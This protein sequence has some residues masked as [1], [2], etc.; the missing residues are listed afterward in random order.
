MSVA[1]IFMNSELPE[2]VL[3]QYPS[4]VQRIQSTFIDLLVIIVLMFGFTSILDRFND[5]PNWIPVAIF[6]GIWFV[7]EPFCTAFGCTLGNYIKGIRVRRQND[8]SRRIPF[9]AALLRYVV[10]TLLGWIS[11]LTINTNTQRRAIHDFAAESVM[12]KI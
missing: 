11:F 8:F 1:N 6:S 5:V 3:A 2:A 7:Y 9:H 12:I 10:K 4:L